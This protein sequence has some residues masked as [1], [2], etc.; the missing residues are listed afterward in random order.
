M[1]EFLMVIVQLTG[2]AFVI[3]QTLKSDRLEQYLLAFA[4]MTVLLFVNL[5][6]NGWA[7][8]S[9]L[10]RTACVLILAWSSLVSI[11]W[12]KE[13]RRGAEQGDQSE[14]RAVL[15]ILK[16]PPRHP[17]SIDATDEGVGPSNSIS[18]M[19]NYQLIGPGKPILSEQQLK[20]IIRKSRIRKPPD[21]AGWLGHVLGI[22]VVAALLIGI[23]R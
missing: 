7:D 1:L 2:L 17:R 13:C 10:E 5:A 6:F 23:L 4:P 22:A 15:D 3:T 9:S 18:E 16:R 11:R 19:R 14:E 8:M 20:E 12:V 21:Y